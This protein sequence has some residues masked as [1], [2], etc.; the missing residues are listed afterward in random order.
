MKKLI[1]LFLVLIPTFVLS[2]QSQNRTG[3]ILDKKVMCDDFAKI[4]ES[5]VSKEFNEVPFWIGEDPESKTKYAVMINQ[6]TKTW[7]VIQYNNELACIVG[8][9]EKFKILDTSEKI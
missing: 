8:A 1:V 9:G 6:K 4:I 3:K 5:L 7:T 2:Q